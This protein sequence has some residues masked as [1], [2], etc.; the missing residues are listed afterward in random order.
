MRGSPAP[1]HSEVGALAS[2][3]EAGRHW[4]TLTRPGSARSTSAKNRSTASRG[5]PTWLPSARCSFIR[6]IISAISLGEMSL[7]ACEI[8]R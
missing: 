8:T 4:V 7:A 5:R 2:T 1:P 6:L 3:A